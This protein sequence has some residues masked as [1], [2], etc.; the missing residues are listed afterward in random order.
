MGQEKKRIRRL[1][2]VAI[3]TG[4]STL[5]PDISAASQCPRSLGHDFS[6]DGLVPEGCA[7]EDDLK[8]IE[9]K[10]L[11]P[12]LTLVAVCQLRWPQGNRPVDLNAGL[13]F[14]QYTNGEIPH[15][16][17]L[18]AGRL[19]L[20]GVLRIEAGPAGKYWFSPQPSLVEKKG[21]LNAELGTL[22]FHDEQAFERQLH[23]PKAFRQVCAE[24]DI[25][26]AVDNIYLLL[27]DNDEAGA[28][29]VYSRVLQDDN[30]RHCR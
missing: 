2:F 29:P 1:W 7:C 20:R 5:L 11:P 6:V 4:L 27:G 24:A 8:K 17:L 26:L 3:A 14:D 30:Y 21:P 23:I 22:E 28:I 15:G 19:V 25:V 9:A 12:W 18:L 10:T 16:S 13:T